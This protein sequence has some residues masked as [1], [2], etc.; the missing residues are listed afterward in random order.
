MKR[1]NTKT[2]FPPYFKNKT[3]LVEQKITHTRQP[4]YLIVHLFPASR[5]DTS[6][7]RNF[8]S[9]KGYVRSSGGFSSHLRQP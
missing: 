8:T 5:R 7:D 1:R 4:Y 2:L 9:T 6:L 3:T